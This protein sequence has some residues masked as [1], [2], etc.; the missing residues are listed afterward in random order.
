MTGIDKTPAKR[1]MDRAVW[2]GGKLLDE[3]IA[4]NK[5]KIGRVQKNISGYNMPL[6][7]RNPQ[8]PP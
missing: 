7:L 1:V 2:S 6:S 4:I 8:T 5:G 3:K